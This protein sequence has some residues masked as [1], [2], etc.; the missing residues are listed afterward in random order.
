MTAR[1]VIRWAVLT[2]GVVVVV[3]LALFATVMVRWFGDF[4]AFLVAVALGGILLAALRFAFAR[5]RTPARLSDPFARDMFSTD[6]INIAHIRVAGIGGA[7][8][9]LA[10]MLA[11]LEYQLTTI[12]LA[13]GICGGVLG[14]L[15]VILTRRLRHS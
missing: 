12:A 13:L 2:V 14:A 11:A 4:E 9:V 6:V 1:T 8:L 3:C 7:G 10:A 15:A 5:G